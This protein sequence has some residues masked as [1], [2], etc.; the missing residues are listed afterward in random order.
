MVVCVGWV[1]GKLWKN[2][3][4]AGRLSPGSKLEQG[5]V[6][7]ESKR[8]GGGAKSCYRRAKARTWRIAGKDD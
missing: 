4:R 1:G 3:R 2:R 7:E 6:L 8:N 5:T